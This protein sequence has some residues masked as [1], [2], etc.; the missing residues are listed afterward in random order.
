MPNPLSC[1]TNKG[2]IAAIEIKLISSPKPALWYFLANNSE[3][4]LTSLSFAKRQTL[5][6]TQ[7]KKIPINALT[8]NVYKIAGPLPYAQPLPPRK[9]NVV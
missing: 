5:G 3:I 4:V 9:V 7:Y 8:A 6:C 1:K 2:T